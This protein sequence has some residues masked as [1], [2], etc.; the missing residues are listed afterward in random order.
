MLFSVT[1]GILWKKY[2]P[3]SIRN[4]MLELEGNFETILSFS[5]LYDMFSFL[6]ICLKGTDPK[7]MPAF[8]CVCAKSQQRA[9]FSTHK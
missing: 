1:L 6:M 4:G 8:T 5:R 2:S 3:V 7:A 9:W